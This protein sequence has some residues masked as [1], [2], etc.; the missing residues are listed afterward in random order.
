MP[1]VKSKSKF[2]KSTCSYE[3][4]G[5]K[6]GSEILKDQEYLYDTDAKKGYCL[7]HEELN[8]KVVESTGRPGGW[9][10]GGGVQLCRPVPEAMEAITLWHKTVI[11][12]I[13]ETVKKLCGNSPE[14]KMYRE[15]FETVARQ[16]EEI[17][18]GKHTPSQIAK[19]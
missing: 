19:Q 8:K 16:Y 12:M 5:M 14:L 17:F 10:G 1:I 2:D 6:C 3:K 7:K 13:D 9:K 18:L 15:N 11:P 4:D